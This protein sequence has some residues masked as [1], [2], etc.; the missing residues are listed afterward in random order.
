MALF[1][2]VGVRPKPGLAEKVENDFRGKYYKVAN[3]HW[4]VVG[5][6]TAQSVSDGLG[7]RGGGL[8]SVLVYN[9]VGYYGF[10]STTLWEWLKNSGSDA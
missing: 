2:I 3:N 4:I 10:A 9:F 6:G 8:G 7:I 1:A 5:E